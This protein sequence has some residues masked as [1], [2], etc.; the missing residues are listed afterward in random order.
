MGAIAG[1]SAWAVAQQA[2]ALLVG[3][4]C[5]AGWAWPVLAVSVAAIIVAGAGLAVSWRAR[6]QGGAPHTEPGGGS[7]RFIATLSMGLA[8]IFILAILAQVLAAALLS[9]CER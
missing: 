9:G 2:S 1:F 7:R 6:R 4:S 8:S 5:A 3:R